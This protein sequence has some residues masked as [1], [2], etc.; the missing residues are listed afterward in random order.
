[1]GKEITSYIILN[2]VA[3]TSFIVETILIVYLKVAR[4][5]PRVGLKY[6]DFFISKS[7]PTIVLT[8]SLFFIAAIFL[9]WTRSYTYRHATSISSA[10]L[11]LFLVHCCWA[12]AYLR[13]YFTNK[14]D[15]RQ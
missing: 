14:L 2:Y 4:N 1:M 7:I 5:S 8:R 12:Y 6:L 11:V 10:Y 3:F 13:G 9:F 15:D